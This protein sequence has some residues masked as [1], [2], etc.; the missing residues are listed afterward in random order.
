MVAFWALAFVAGFAG[1]F[2]GSRIGERV[3]R[4]K[5]LPSPMTKAARA[6]AKASKLQGG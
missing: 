4:A 1:G 5:Y 2:Y 6:L 3:R